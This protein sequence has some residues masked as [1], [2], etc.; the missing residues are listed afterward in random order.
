M[1]NA[2]VAVSKIIGSFY[3]TNLNEI[4]VGGKFEKS[5]L[6]S[7]RLIISP[8]RRFRNNNRNKG[9]E[10]ERSPSIQTSSLIGETG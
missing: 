4:F 9:K 3:Q 7:V 10:F 1:A 8:R 6:Y 2:T 5:T